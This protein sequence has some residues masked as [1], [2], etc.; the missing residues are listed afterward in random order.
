MTPFIITA[1]NRQQAIERITHLDPTQ[2]WEMKI[3]QRKSKRSLEQ[4][5][6]MRGF[7]SDL[8]KHL[9]YSP[10]DMYALLMYKFCPEYIK[11]PVTKEEIRKPGHFSKKQ[12]GTPR[13]TK[14]AADVQDA[15]QRW[16]EELG[17]VWENAA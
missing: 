10:D 9:G 12:D 3:S 17:F 1:N 4:N 15:V 13:N 7:A 16:A 14:E 2:Q 8:G 11:D 5:S 6:W